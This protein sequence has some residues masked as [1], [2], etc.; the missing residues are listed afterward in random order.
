MNIGA[1]SEQPIP[2]DQP[3]QVPTR[4]FAPHYCTDDLGFLD[5]ARSVSLLDAE[6]LLRQ[7][8]VLIKAQPWMGKTTFATRMH[9]WLSDDPT[10]R[11]IF[12]TFHEL[13]CFEESISVLQLMPRWWTQWKSSQ[14]AGAACWII[15]GLD[16]C[17]PDQ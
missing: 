4:R 14:P 10:Q 5:T 17:E 1:Q 13:N 12:G 15:D 2:E 7:P 16:E 6:G 11:A 9:A 3:A 8:A